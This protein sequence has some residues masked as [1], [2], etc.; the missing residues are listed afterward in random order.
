MKSHET[1]PSS[2][3]AMP[4]GNKVLEAIQIFKDVCTAFSPFFRLR[5]PG[6]WRN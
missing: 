1:D 4:L 2:L 3:L 5:R 6:T